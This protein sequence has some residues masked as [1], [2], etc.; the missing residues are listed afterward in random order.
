MNKKSVAP[1]PPYSRR[2]FFRYGVPRAI[3]RRIFYYFS[4][5]TIV[6][7]ITLTQGRCRVTRAHHGRL[8]GLLW[9]APPSGPCAKDSRG[10]VA[11]AAHFPSMIIIIIIIIILKM[12]GGVL[13]FSTFSC[14]SRWLVISTGRPSVWFIERRKTKKNGRNRRRRVFLALPR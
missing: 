14:W 9:S 6:V 12:V 5:F 2:L 7:I 13:Q 4:N 11:S 1:S 8:G 3:F 10:F